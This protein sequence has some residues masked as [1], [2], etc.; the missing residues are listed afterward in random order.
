MTTE[1][2]GDGG[3][4]VEVVYALPER[5]WSVQL[6]LPEASTVAD[7]LSRARLELV[8]GVA[9]VDP[10]RL[11]I[12]SRLVLPS[13]ILRDGDRLEVLRP[14]TADPKLSRR[15]RALESTP[16]KK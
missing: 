5:Y 11:A 8:E 15:N 1:Q 6:R 3:M 14:L 16:R 2:A 4:R 12:Y 10:G 9:D 7:A 13:T